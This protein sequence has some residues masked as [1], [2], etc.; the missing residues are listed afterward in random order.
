LS[1]DWRRAPFYE[2]DGLYYFNIG[3]CII[4]CGLLIRM[5]IYELIIL[6]IK[7][8]FIIVIIPYIVIYI[9][10]IIRFVNLLV[11]TPLR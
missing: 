7:G 3:Y 1:E 6:I 10:I 5:A 8:L 4:A 11:S 2:V 9:L